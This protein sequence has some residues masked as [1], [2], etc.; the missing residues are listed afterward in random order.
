M[1]SMNNYDNITEAKREIGK[2]KLNEFLFPFVQNWIPQRLQSNKDFEADLADLYEDLLSVV[3]TDFEH[4]AFAA[5]KQ[6]EKTLA[7]AQAS[8]RQMAD[9]LLPIIL[10]KQNIP[11]ARRES[12]QAKY[13]P[14][15]GGY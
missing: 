9:E 12:L 10:N 13:D 3:M 6:A 15:E 2:M 4:E 8:Y 7:S 14:S 5:A 1:F 11:E